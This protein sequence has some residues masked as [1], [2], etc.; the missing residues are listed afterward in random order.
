MKLLSLYFQNYFF[1]VSKCNEY[2]AEYFNYSKQFYYLNS[3]L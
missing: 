3:N 1:N 2:T